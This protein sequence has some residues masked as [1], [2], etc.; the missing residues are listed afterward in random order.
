MCE[1]SIEGRGGE[2]NNRFHSRAKGNTKYEAPRVAVCD[3]SH[4]G[5]LARLTCFCR[6]TQTIER[7]VPRA[8]VVVTE[9]QQ[10]LV[11]VAVCDASNRGRVNSFTGLLVT[12]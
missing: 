12:V 8:N 2:E 1:A 9:I 6:G 7:V 5:V 3:T 10:Q 11:R 4:C